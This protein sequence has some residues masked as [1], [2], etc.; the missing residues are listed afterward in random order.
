[1]MAAI[2]DGKENSH[3]EELKVSESQRSSFLED[4]STSL[5]TDRFN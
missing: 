1:M 3:A 5:N 2:T 4:V